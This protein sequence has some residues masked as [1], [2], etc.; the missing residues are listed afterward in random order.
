MKNLPALRQ[1]GFQ[2]NRRLLDVQQVSHDCSLGENAFDQVVRP[3]TV[4][5]QRAAAL[6][7]GDRRARALFAVPVVFRLELRGVTNAE[8]RVLIAQL[9]SLDSA[10][11]PAGRMTYDLRRYAC[12]ASSSASPAAIAT[13]SQSTAC[14]SPCSSPVPMPT[15]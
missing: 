13:N 9:L 11:Y 1:V 8:M 2:A 5:G 10:H 7:F 15:C 14:A 6:K 12:T 4:E 3:V